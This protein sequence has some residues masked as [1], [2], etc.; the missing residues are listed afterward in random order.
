MSNADLADAYS[1]QEF[2][3]RHRISRPFFYKLLAQGLGPRVLRL[4]SRTLVTREA[5]AAWRAERE[6]ATAQL[7]NSAA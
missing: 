7:D 3:E 5:A 1:V 2:C 6:A 4:G